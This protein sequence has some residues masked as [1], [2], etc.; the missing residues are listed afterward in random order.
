MRVSS[1]RVSENVSHV[2]RLSNRSLNCL[3]VRTVQCD[4]VYSS[5]TDLSLVVVY[6][7]L[8]KN[9]SNTQKMADSPSCNVRSTR[10]SGESVSENVSV[11]S[12]L[13]QFGKGKSVMGKAFEITKTPKKYEY[14]K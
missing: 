14:Y 4:L 3:A 8:R 5:S 6:E 9:F 11:S 2:Q 7:Y 1:E 13:Q 10:V 12:I